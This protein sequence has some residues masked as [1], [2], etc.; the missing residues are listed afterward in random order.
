VTPTSRSLALLRKEGLLAE[1]V[2][3]WNSF[4]R[5]KKDLL[6]FIDIVALAPEKGVTWGVQCTTADNLAARV[7]KITMEC[8]E[9]AE[10]WLRCGNKIAVIGWAKRGPRG[11]R[12]FWTPVSREVT[13]AD[14]E[15]TMECRTD[16]TR[17]QGEEERDSC[18]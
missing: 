14:L 7:R 12:K 4:S 17:R 3:K 11:C 18:P 10:A 6:G 16:P 13:V 1:V 5:T 15:G 9:A 8:R 2:E